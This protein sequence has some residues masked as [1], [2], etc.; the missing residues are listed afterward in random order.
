MAIQFVAS[1][2]SAGTAG[3]AQKTPTPAG[4]TRQAA[5]QTASAPS[6]EQVRQAVGE[7]QRVIEPAAHNLDFSIDEE[8][9]RTV[10]RVVDST[11]KEVIRQIP[12]EEVI[13]ISHA[14]NRLAGL[15]VQE[16]A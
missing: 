16:K 10:V 15:L 5:A 6:P 8:S 12:S 2:S 9:G 4:S 14:I 11:T 3:P 7:I 13:S 1:T